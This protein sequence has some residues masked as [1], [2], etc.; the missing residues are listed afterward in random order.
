VPNGNVVPPGPYMLFVERPVTVNGAR[1]WIPSVS[2]QVF[3]GATAPSYSGSFAPT[4]TSRVRTPS[5]NAA[6]RPVAATAPRAAAASPTMKLHARP[7]AVRRPYDDWRAL[8]IG[9]AAVLIGL[10]ARWSVARRVRRA[11]PVRG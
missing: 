1:K 4:S 3:V 6:P 7:V 11:G 5:S 9:V 8:W 10:R 2:R